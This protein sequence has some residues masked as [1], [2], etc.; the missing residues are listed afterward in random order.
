MPHFTHHNLCSNVYFSHIFYFL[1]QCTFLYFLEYMAIS[2]MLL[3]DHQTPRQKD[4]N[5][6]G[7]FFS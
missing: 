5:E 3:G 1:V 6:E 2:L 4:K 7:L